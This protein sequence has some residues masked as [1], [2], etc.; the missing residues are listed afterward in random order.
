MRTKTTLWVIVC[1]LCTFP[2]WATTFT[3]GDFEFATTGAD[4]CRLSKYL[5][6]GG[7]VTIPASASDGTT[8]YAVA[9]IGSN[10]FEGCT[11]LTSVTLPNSITKI[12][13]NAFDR[14]SNL[15]SINF[16]PSLTVIGYAAFLRCGSLTSA[17]LP[18]SVATI[19][20]DAFALCYNLAS[21]TLPSAIKEIGWHVFNSCRSLTS[22][23]IP[24]KVTTLGWGAF[25]DCS[26]LTSVA[27]GS[28]VTTIDGDAF[29]NCSNLTSVAIPDKVT[30]IGDYAFRNCSRLAAVACLAARP[31]VLGERVFE[32]VATGCALTV[33]AGSVDAYAGSDIAAYFTY[34]NG[35]VNL[36]PATGF[37][38][39]GTAGNLA[40][41][42]SD[43]TLTIS[44]AGKMDNYSSTY[45]LPWSSYKKR[46]AT[47]VIE[48][49]TTSIGRN[50][51]SYCSN[52]AAVVIPN[53]VTT[54]GD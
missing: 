6:D 45:T 40:W 3:A 14:C 24:D 4:A 22:V 51:F 7:A 26:G 25:E 18:N 20:G 30:T 42:I 29:R 48:N 15:V 10:A 37:V 52:L 23:T 49:G 21:V 34:I 32:S 39:S 41:T 47:A 2:A 44:C 19:G 54:I 53:S 46:I 1:A 17:T 33:S 8:A 43:S 16:P 11:G 28:S 5:G 12:G 35:E 36:R 13:S 9:E 50:A 38:H 31:P 27:I